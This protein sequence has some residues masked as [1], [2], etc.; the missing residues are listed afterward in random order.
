MHQDDPDEVQRAA[1]AFFDRTL[2]GVVSQG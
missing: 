1:H 2:A